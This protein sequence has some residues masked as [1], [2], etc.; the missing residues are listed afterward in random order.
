MIRH[1]KEMKEYTLN[2]GKTA[3][4]A[5]L[6]LITFNS[7]SFFQKAQAQNITELISKN[8]TAQTARGN[9]QMGYIDKAVLC[10]SLAVDE[11]KKQ[12]NSG[13]GVDGTLMAEYAYALALHHDF[14]AALINIDRARNLGTKYGDFYAAQILSMMG[15]TE[16]ANELMRDS[17]IPDWVS[18]FYLSYKAKYAVKSFSINSEAPQMALDRANRLAANQQTIQAVALYEELSTIYPNTYIIHI[19]YSTLWESLAHYEYAQKLL[20]KGISLMPTD[21]INRDARTACEEHLRKL[22]VQDSITNRTPLVKKMQTLPTPKIMNYVG[23]SAAKESFSVNG[24]VGLY[25][26]KKFS[27]T[28]NL[29]ISLISGNIMESI[30]I[31]TYKSFSIFVVGLGISGQFANEAISLGLS[32]SVGLT[33]LNKEQTS[34]FDITWGFFLPITSDGVFS[35]NLSLGKTYYIDIKN[36]RK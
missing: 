6:F 14:E 7:Y 33:F 31:S 17:E 8:T 15:Y 28:M 32:P 5:F 35:Y 27:Y 29:G 34:S 3:Y 12:R 25:T 22:H 11:A 9:L 1:T 4:L 2:I 36:Q 23:L 16:P 24:K 19:D 26:T 30:G 20:S 18:P 13:S 21:T 10:Y